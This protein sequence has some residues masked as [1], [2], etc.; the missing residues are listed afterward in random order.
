MNKYY[1]WNDFEHV[2]LEDSF[3]LGIE[4]LE[5]QVIFNLAVVLVES[6]PLYVTPKE[7]EQYCYK[8][9]RIFFHNVESVRW[10]NKNMQPATD[11]NG[12]VDFGNID[13]FE[14]TVNGY[15]L[16]GSWGEM[17]IKSSK[18]LLTWLD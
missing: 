18:P 2:Y 8:R 3:V 4:E 7:D 12:E 15:Y 10:I 16:E 5:E 17:T 14:L 13:V 6:H 11:A 1:E 9:G